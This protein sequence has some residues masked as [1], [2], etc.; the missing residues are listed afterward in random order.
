MSSWRRS[1]SEL[2]Q[3]LKQVNWWRKFKNHVRKVPSS[4]QTFIESIKTYI[5]KLAPEK[6]PAD[7]R[8]V[9]CWC[10]GYKFVWKYF[11]Y[12]LCSANQHKILRLTYCSFS[13]TKL[14]NLFWN[15]DLVFAKKLALKYIQLRLLLPKLLHQLV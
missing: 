9:N 8:F 11:D 7:I 10:V 3:I 6:I 12:W 2:K 5:W 15:R 14:L 13:C 4:F 1:V